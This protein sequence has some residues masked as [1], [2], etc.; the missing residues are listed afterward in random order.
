MAA[1]LHPKEKENAAFVSTR[2]Q[3]KLSVSA[4]FSAGLM[5][6][7]LLSLNTLIRII[8]SLP[9]FVKK[10]FLSGERPKAESKEVKNRKGDRGTWMSGTIEVRLESEAI[11]GPYENS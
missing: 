4:A 11:I 5:L 3:R 6:S 2:K 7:H 8:H 10:E 9:F 1:F